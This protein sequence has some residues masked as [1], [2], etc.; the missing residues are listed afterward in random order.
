MLDGP[1]LATD[2][3]FAAFLSGFPPLEGPQS[4]PLPPA[5]RAASQAR[6]VS[7]A[8]ARRYICG[9]SYFDC[10]L[11]EARTEYFKVGRLD[12]SPQAVGLVLQGNGDLYTP[13]VLLTFGPGGQRRGGHILGGEIGDMAHGYDGR[14]SADGLSLT[15]ERY[16]WAGG[17]ERVYVED[18][19]LQIRPS[20]AVDRVIAP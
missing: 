19:S 8:D 6:P 16:V 11:D 17:A 12:I 7:A 20:G 18:L 13:A 9:A 4:F 10:R 1:F 3:T 5:A 15:V 2:P 14:L